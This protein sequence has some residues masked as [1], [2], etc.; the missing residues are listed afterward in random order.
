MIL[1]FNHQFNHHI[2]I[3]IY[4]SITIYGAIDLLFFAPLSATPST[5]EAYLYTEG[6]VRFCSE[7]FSLDPAEL[8]NGCVHL[9]NNEARRR[10]YPRNET[11]HVDPD[12]APR[13]Y[14]VI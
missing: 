5:P 10:L 3:Y 13:K 2:N 7:A 11:G 4:I 8:C 1:I 9:T 6:L 12:V 14:M